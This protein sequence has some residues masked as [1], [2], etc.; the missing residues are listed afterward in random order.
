MRVK[1]NRLLLS[2]LAIIFAISSCKKN[3][4][5][6]NSNQLLEKQTIEQFTKVPKGS[7]PILQQIAD[8]LKQKDNQNP[9]LANLSQRA[10][11]PIWASSQIKKRTTNTAARG[12][13]DDYTLVFVPLSIP[14]TQDVDGFLAC[15]VSATDVD[16]DL[17]EDKYFANYGF[18]KPEGEIDAEEVAKKSMELEYE[19]FGHSD[20][21]VIDKRLF[22]ENVNG[23]SRK[24]FN[25]TLSEAIQT[26][27]AQS[28]VIVVKNNHCTGHTG[29]GPNGHEGGDCDEC[30]DCGAFEYTLIWYD[31]FF[32]W[33]GGV[34]GGFG[35]GGEG[36][37]GS[38]PH[39]PIGW[40]YVPVIVH[41]MNNNP[42]PSI[43]NDI[44]NKTYTYTPFVSSAN[45]LDFASINDNTLANTLKTTYQQLEEAFKNKPIDKYTYMPRDEFIQMLKDH[46]NLL[47]T[48]D[49]VTTLIKMG[50]NAAVDALMQTL[51]IRLT[52]PTVTSWSEAVGKIDK[53]QVGATAVSGLFTWKNTTTDKL[54][55]A[56]INGITA[57]I[58]DL[59]QK[60]FISWEHTGVTFVMGFGASLVGNLAGD[61]LVS[62][63]GSVS[64]FGKALVK[65]MGN[66]IPYKFV[67]N[68]LGGGL[69]TISKSFP[70]STAFTGL[71]TAERKM[72]G[73]AAGKVAVIGRNMK[74]RVTP[75]AN[76]LKTELGHPVETFKVPAGVHGEA[77]IL[78]ANKAWVQSLKEQGYTFYD[79]GLDPF[80]SSGLAIAGAEPD[81]ST[82]IFYAMEIFEIF[83][84]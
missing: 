54:I 36:G 69:K 82:G 57:V 39:D 30:D 79:V 47:P 51:I 44:T 66:K 60:G 18:G 4:I 83:G 23:V 56:G 80:Y 33:G 78:A 5:I 35:G 65:I 61:Y 20:F 9:F 81:L 77:A 17:F 40:I 1:Q 73:W 27:Q 75:F 10:G 29:T 32:D 38:V 13:D 59:A 68:W 62:K 7:N 25:V 67:C 14:N 21:K 41:T 63:F 50:T 31:S 26:V 19:A 72:D 49:P 12:V 43:Y 37:G 16:I 11:L 52:D 42:L 46:P 71:V 55:L 70:S 45:E 6:V 53:Y 84:N 64:N 24:V 34:S 3:D 76:Q 28:R 74:D 58:S 22:A 8:K 15:K 2:L 48:I